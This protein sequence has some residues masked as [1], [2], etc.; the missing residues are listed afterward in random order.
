MNEILYPE[1]MGPV[2][3]DTPVEEARRRRR[4]Y[5]PS[6]DAL[7]F[8]LMPFVCIACFGFPTRY[9]TI[10]ATLSGFAPLCF[11]IL[12]GFFAL[13]GG[14]REQRRLKRGMRQSAIMFLIM[15]LVCFASNILYYL[16][17]GMEVGTLFSALS[18]KR[19][20]F[21][22]FALCAWPF[23]MGESIWFIQSLLYAYVLLYGMHLLK[24][25]RL[26][27]V[28][29]AACAVLTVLSGELAG[30]IGFRFL[31]YGYLPPN[32]LTC[33]LPYM[34]LGG[35]LREKEDA[36]RKKKA[37][38]YLLMVPLGLALAYG[39]FALLGRLGML[40]TTS[41]AIGLGLAAFGLCAWV[42]LYVDMEPNFCCF[43][44]RRFSKIIY[45]SS[46]PVAFLLIVPMSAFFPTGALLVQVLGGL[47]VYPVC[48]GLALVLDSTVFRN[49]PM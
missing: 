17:T 11:Y 31:G 38:V 20:L 35:L 43:V 37:W 34:L 44:G 12:C 28:V 7:K 18:G 45:L 1:N 36:L 23:P 39:E 41:H 30:V 4:G 33:A 42:M 26:R 8:W 22:F 16:L 2:E 14:E 21:N 27:P 13:T 5:R 24:L 19:V 49:N 46:Q 32:A 3:A 9:G 48:L 25:R 6:A 40:V 15:F 10:V 47:I 29:L